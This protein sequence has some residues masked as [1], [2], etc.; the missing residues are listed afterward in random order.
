M[1]G[2]ASCEIIKFCRRGCLHENINNKGPIAEL[3][4]IYKHIYNDISRMVASLKD[5]SKFCD[6]IQRE[7]YDA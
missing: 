1:T 5:S 4:L 2:C 6:L 7:L 3:C